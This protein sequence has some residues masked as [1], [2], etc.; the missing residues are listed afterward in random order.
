M[1]QGVLN[2]DGDVPPDIIRRNGAAEIEAAVLA[3]IRPKYGI[4]LIEEKMRS[5]R[6]TFSVP[7]VSK[8]VPPPCFPPAPRSVRVQAAPW[9]LK[10]ASSRLKPSAASAAR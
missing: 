2:D 10:N 5:L 7:E 1:A 9:A 6:Y 8:A 3:P 4:S